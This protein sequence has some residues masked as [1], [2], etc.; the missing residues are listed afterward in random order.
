MFAC[1]SPPPLPR[2]PPTHTPTQCSE[3]G[4]QRQDCCRFNYDAMLNFNGDTAVYLLYSHARIASILR[5]AEAAKG[6]SIDQLKEESKLQ[7]HLPFTSPLLP[8]QLSRLQLLPSDAG[9]GHCL[10]QS[11]GE[12]AASTFPKPPI[13]PFPSSVPSCSQPQT[14]MKQ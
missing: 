8:P 14:I 5:K 4:H 9:R 7:V 10:Q 1:L 2:A 11:E 6:V 13:Q 12:Q 3:T